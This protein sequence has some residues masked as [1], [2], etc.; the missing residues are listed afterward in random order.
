MWNKITAHSWLEFH[1]LAAL[2][3]YRMEWIYTG[4][5]KNSTQR[6]ICDKL[7]A[8][9]L[10]TTDWTVLHYEEVSLRLWYLS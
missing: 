8:H 10:N 7:Q 6:Y 2:G 1:W 9:S 5:K 3:Q 4:E